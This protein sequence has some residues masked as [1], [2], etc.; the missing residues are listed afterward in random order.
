MRLNYNADLW[1]AATAR[2]MLSQ[3]DAAGRRR[4]RSGAAHHGPAAAAPEA[5][6]RPPRRNADV[7]SRLPALR[8]A[9]AGS[10]SAS[11]S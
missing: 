2:A 8:R 1:E 5:R 9:E 7:I 4:G 10:P 11:A 6:Q 3:Y